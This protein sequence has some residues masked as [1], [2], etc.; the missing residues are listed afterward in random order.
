M[1]SPEYNLDLVHLMLD[2][3]KDYVLSTELFWSLGQK[4]PAGSPP[5][6]SLTLGSLLLTLDQLEAQARD[7]PPR[8][9]TQFQ[10]VQIKRSHVISKWPV[11]LENKAHKE[12]HTRYNLWQAYIHDLEEQNES[13]ENYAREVRNRVMFER[14]LELASK[15]AG[16]LSLVQAMSILDERLREF[17]I[18]GE[19]IWA[20]ALHSIYP[21][22]T[23]WFLYG[24][25]KSLKE[26]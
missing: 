2:Q 25:P 14:L 24:T 5:Y 18:P 16:T 10:R 22:P 15:H 6:P 1:Y 19:F 8:L 4:A 21:S 7:M 26:E 20:S 11:G 12:L 23:F 17:F 13:P 9:H 3:I